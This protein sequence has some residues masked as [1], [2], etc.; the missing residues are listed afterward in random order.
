MMSDNGTDCEDLR[1]WVGAYALGSLD[2]YDRQTLEAHL[3]ECPD[4]RA[5]LHDVAGVVPLLATVTRADLEPI[6]A[7]PDLLHRVVAA[8]DAAEQ[9]VHTPTRHR[10]LLVAAAC[11]VLLIGIGAGVLLVSHNGVSTS[12]TLAT[13]GTVH[14]AVTA[15]QRDGRTKL[16]LK[17]DGLPADEHC[18]LVAVAGDGSRHEAG[19]WTAAYTGQAHVVEFTDVPRTQ[20]KHL[21]LYGTDGRA[22]VRA[23]F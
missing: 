19:T 17:V 21:I 14:M 1:M 12:S 9:P 13:A 5:E 16:D 11:L 15:T 8:I 2:A 4:C 6:S 23:T 7:P 3:A 18:R 22:L 10:W 20:L